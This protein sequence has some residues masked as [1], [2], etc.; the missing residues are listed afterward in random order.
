M[1]EI[2]N[3][4]VLF[5]KKWDK[6]GVMEVSFDLYSFGFLQ[7]SYLCNDRFLETCSCTTYE[8]PRHG[9]GYHLLPKPLP[10]KAEDMPKDN[11]YTKSV[12]LLTYFCN[13]LIQIFENV[14][15]TCQNHKI[16]YL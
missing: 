2:T 8:M 10:S 9:S 12:Y 13:K 6:C 15:Y 1:L 11:K 14:I 4:V 5:L 7:L 3:S 16:F